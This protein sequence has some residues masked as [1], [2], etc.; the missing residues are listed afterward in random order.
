MEYEI[1]LKKIMRMRR[2]VFQLDVLAVLII[3]I[4]IA[5]V[6]QLFIPFVAPVMGVVL[7]VRFYLK[8]ERVAHYPCL[9]CK[10]PFGSSSKVVLGL[11][12]GV[13]QSC[14]LKLTMR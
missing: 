11:G 12:K 5:V 4:A 6:L 3:A 8:L 9:R 1:E 2:D 10:E 13:C 7:F 14:G